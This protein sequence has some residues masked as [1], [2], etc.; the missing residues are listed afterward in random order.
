VELK[1]VAI[2]TTRAGHDLLRVVGPDQHR[3]AV[4]AI[5]ERASSEC[6]NTWVAM[7]RTA[8]DRTVAAATGNTGPSNCLPIHLI[9][10]GSGVEQADPDLLP[11]SVLARQGRR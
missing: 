6:T 2:R 9:H 5:A 3:G 7:F 8:R 10:A 11:I 1:V 4:L